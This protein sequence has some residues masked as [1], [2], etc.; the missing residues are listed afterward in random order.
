MQVD[1]NSFTIQV[2]RL[3]VSGVTKSHLYTFSNKCAMSLST[4]DELMRTCQKNAPHIPYL[5][6]KVKDVK[7]GIHV[8]DGALLCTHLRNSFTSPYSTEECKSIKFYQIL[9]SNN[10][11][12]EALLV[13]KWVAQSNVFSQGKRSPLCFDPELTGYR[14]LFAIHCF[15]ENRIEQAMQ[16]AK[17]C[18]KDPESEGD[19]FVATLTALG[20]DVASKGNDHETAKQLLEKAVKIDP[21]YDVALE[22]LGE[23]YLPTDPLKAKEYFERALAQNPSNPTALQHLGAL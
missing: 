17:I 3:P 16:W 2:N 23:L 1:P 8:Y 12:H 15:N 19:I 4:F 21:N 20:L 13:D 11:G 18:V 6:A 14:V 7:G 9:N 10:I 5:I 22:R